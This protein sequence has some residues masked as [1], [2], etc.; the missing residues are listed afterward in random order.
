LALRRTRGNVEADSGV[1]TSGRCACGRNTWSARK[2]SH[3]RSTAS[4]AATVPA[5][6]AS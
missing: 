6:S 5:P 2:R 4:S 1:R 3:T